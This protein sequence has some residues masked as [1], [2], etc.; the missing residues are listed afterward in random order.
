MIYLDDVLQTLA[1]KEVYIQGGRWFLWIFRNP[2]GT[3]LCRAHSIRRVVKT[4]GFKKKKEWDKG[5]RA[6]IGKATQ[7]PSDYLSLFPP[8]G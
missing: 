4:G 5:K 3:E 6:R 8:H 2:H 7:G 1:G